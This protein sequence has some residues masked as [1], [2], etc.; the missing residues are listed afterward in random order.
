VEYYTGNATLVTADA[1]NSGGRD[2]ADPL[3]IAP[4]TLKPS[5]CKDRGYT[6]EYCTPF[7]LFTLA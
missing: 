3:T 2:Q 1:L 6:H 5:E 7:E 4:Q